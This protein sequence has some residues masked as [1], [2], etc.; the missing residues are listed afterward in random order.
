M[1]FFKSCLNLT[2][3]SLLTCTGLAAP[4]LG[5]PLS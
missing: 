4:V 1:K 5:V 3:L 2:L